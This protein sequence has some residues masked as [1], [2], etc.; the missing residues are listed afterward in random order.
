MKMGGWKRTSVK[1]KELVQTGSGGDHGQ[2]GHLLV[3]DN[4]QQ[5]RA[6]AVDEPRQGIDDVLG[7]RDLA[8]LDMHC[9]G[10]LL[11]I[12]VALVS[13]GISILVEE[14]L[15]LGDHTLLLVVQ[16]NDLDTDVE[17]SSGG[18]LGEGHVEGSITVD[19][20]DKGVRLGN[21][22]ADGSGKAEAHG[23]QTTRGDHGTGLPPSEVLGS[24]HLMLA[25]TGS[26]VGVVFSVSTQLAELLD[27]SLGLDETSAIGALIVGK[28]PLLLPGVDLAEPLL[29]ILH[30]SN[31]EVG[32][33]LS[34]VGANIALNGL[35]SLDD[36]VNVLGHDLEVDDTTATLGSSSLGTRGELGDAESDTIVESG[37]ES[38]DEIGLLDSHVGVS[39]TVHTKH[40]Q[41][42][43]LKLIVST[44]TLEGSG[45][46]DGALVS[47]LLQDLGTALGEDDTLT[48][49][50]DGL[51]GDVDEITNALEGGR[52]LLLA[53]LHGSTRGSAGERRQASLSGNGSSKDTGGD[54]LGEIDEDGSGSSRGGNLE[55]LVDAAG[56]LG[57]V[58]HHDVPL[59]A[60]SRNSNNIGLLEGIAANGSGDNLT[61]K[62]NHG[63]T[64]R[65]GILHRSNDVG[66]TGTGGDEDDTGLSTSAG[67][68]LSH[69]AST[70]L[71][72]GQDEVE[73]F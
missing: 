17:L 3:G 66:S 54:I 38:D 2:N 65:K 46:G 34:Q 18:E 52:E 60:R 43:L 15:P 20:D 5:G 27:E 53:L 7:F 51:L 32:D 57:N 47:K 13:V 44:K 61:S 6:I 11:E 71:V 24:P 10:E 42:L 39:S 73:V 33:E 29:A 45:N 70:L 35:G 26:D 50:D 64:V 31:L 49:I 19:I 16:D 58:L 48:S 37:T 14:V 63:G 4:L 8:G 22:G 21:L 55:S 69:V 59:C 41:G 23:S 72:S 62:D 67:V 28:G 25:D 68:T 30:G 9:L 1:D 12:G 56:E 40:V 36:L